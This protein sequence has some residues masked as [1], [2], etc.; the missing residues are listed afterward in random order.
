MKIV[1]IATRKADAKPE[2]FA[3]HL[4]T[5]VGVALGM[6]RDEIVREIYSRSDGKGAIIVLECDDEAHA[7]TQPHL[8]WNCSIFPRRCTPQAKT[9]ALSADCAKIR[10][11]T[12]AWSCS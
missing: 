1:A 3:P 2:E 5:E 4:E 10:P 12:M 9:H 8:A 11:P 7:R 6:Y